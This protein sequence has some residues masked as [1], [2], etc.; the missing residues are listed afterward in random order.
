MSRKKL[1]RVDRKTLDLT[2]RVFTRVKHGFEII[3]TWYQTEE[4]RWRWQPCMVILPALKWGKLTP[5][6]IP[7]T[8][9]WRWAMHGDVGD[10][11]HCLERAAEWFLKG[12]L[13]GEPMNKRDHMRLYDAINESL[14]DLIALPPRPKG[15]TYA[16]GDMVINRNGVITEREVVN[17]V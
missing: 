17:D 4:T 13:P 14:P 5:I 8:E 1:L 10:P 12:Y 11:E 3:G 7:Q 16:I 9:A 15:D 6:I 2:Q